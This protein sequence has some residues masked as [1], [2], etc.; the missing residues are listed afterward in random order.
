MPVMFDYIKELFSLKPMFLL[1]Y[2]IYVFFHLKRYEFYT[3]NRINR[4]KEPS[5]FDFSQGAP[6]VC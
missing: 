2:I 4:R 3:Y 6:T 5:D 1:L